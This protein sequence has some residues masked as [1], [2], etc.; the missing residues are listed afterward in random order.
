MTTTSTTDQATIRLHGHDLLFPYAWLTREAGYTLTGS[1][2]KRLVEMV[3]D[4][5]STVCEA[6]TDNAAGLLTDAESAQLDEDV[7]PYAGQA[8]AA[9]PLPCTQPVADVLCALRDIAVEYQAE[10]FLVEDGDGACT[11]DL[12]YLDRI[13]P[14]ITAL[15]DPD[16]PTPPAPGYTSTD[17]EV[18]HALVQICQT[19]R[20][21]DTTTYSLLHGLITNL[22]GNPPETG[23]HGTRWV[24]LS[25]ISAAYDAREIECLVKT[26]AEAV[27]GNLDDLSEIQRELA[28]DAYQRMSAE[29]EGEDDPQ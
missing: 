11:R 1:H 13:T 29:Y 21:L 23:E 5:Y 28:D 17:R 27:N 24:Q 14:L 16:Q 25:G 22:T 8:P 9:D 20:P 7:D 4:G 6:I 10:P 2:L 26:A 3:R 12:D 15:I 19:R 18:Y